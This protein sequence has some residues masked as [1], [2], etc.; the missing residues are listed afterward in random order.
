MLHTVHMFRKIDTNKYYALLGAL[1]TLSKIHKTRFYTKQRQS[2]FE[3]LKEHGIILIL[4]RIEYEDGLSY[5]AIE[6]IMNPMRLLNTDD[7]LTLAELHHLSKI[8]SK[9]KEVFEPIKK[10]FYKKRENKRSIFNFQNLDSYKL[11]RVDFA[12]NIETEFIEYY[13]KLIK[14]S[15][16]PNGF[17]QVSKYDKVSKRRKPFEDSFYLKSI[18]NSSVT[19]NC[20]NKGKQLKSQ[21]LPSSELAKLTI[22]FEVQC[23]YSK[24]YPLG[25]NKINKLSFFLND[26]LSDD[27]L[28]YYFKKTVGFGDYYTLQEAKNLVQ[29]HTRIRL[30]KKEAL[31]KTLEIVSKKRGVWKARKGVDDKKAFDAYI[32]DLHK[33]GINPVTIPNNWEIECLPCLFGLENEE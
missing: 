18:K 29:S 13:M 3:L 1:Q 28:E 27:I 22:R 21:G 5:S 24:I 23:K 20:Y 4:T 26:K 14:R 8:E 7:Y 6:I 16:I 12:I 30:K 10:Q 15:N 33:L 19:I 31:L 9:F 32:K 2:Y 25:K 11:K 17:Y